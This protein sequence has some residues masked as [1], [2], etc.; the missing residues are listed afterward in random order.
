MEVLTICHGPVVLEAEVIHSV[1]TTTQTQFIAIKSY[2]VTP[3]CPDFILKEPHISGG[4]VQLLV[5][6]KMTKL[7][8]NSLIMKV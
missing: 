1:T 4:V 7:I 2:M 5:F 8:M 6:Y 3:W